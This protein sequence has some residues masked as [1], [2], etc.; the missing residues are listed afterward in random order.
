MVTI[1]AESMPSDLTPARRNARRSIQFRINGSFNSKES[2]ISENGRRSF[3]APNAPLGPI[4]IKDFISEG[5]YLAKKED[6]FRK[7]PS[8]R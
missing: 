1:S 2:T 3:V 6:H 5:A 8:N 4:L 7:T